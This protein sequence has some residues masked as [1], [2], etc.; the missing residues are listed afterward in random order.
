MLTAGTI[1]GIGISTAD[2]KIQPLA[3]EPSDQ[4]VAL[5]EGFLERLVDFLDGILDT[6]QNLIERID[7]FLEAIVDLLETLQD[8]FGEGEG[9]G[10]D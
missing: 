2:T 5:D 6:L 1:S 4:T 3:T 7:E 9:S 8:L 10:G